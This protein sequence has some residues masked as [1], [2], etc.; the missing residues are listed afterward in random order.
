MLDL[1]IVLVLIVLNALAHSAYI[2]W[3]RQRRRPHVVRRA[4]RLRGFTY[5]THPSPGFACPPEHAIA[6]RPAGI[7]W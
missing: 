6:V 5:P 3:R 4:A 2:R 7:D 1:A